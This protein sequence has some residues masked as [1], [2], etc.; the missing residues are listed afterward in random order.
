MNLIHTDLSAIVSFHGARLI[1]FAHALNYHSETMT[2]PYRE[3]A[4]EEIRH[5][6]DLITVA[7]V[8]AEEAARTEAEHA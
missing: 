3:M 7:V 5:S 8:A 4:I 6:L 1:G 2:K